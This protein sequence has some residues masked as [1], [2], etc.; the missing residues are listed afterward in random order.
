MSS[1]WRQAKS[2]RTRLYH[3]SNFQN[4]HACQSLG[5]QINSLK[6]TLI[7]A[8]KICSE[9]MIAH[10][11]IYMGSLTQSKAWVKKS[12][13]KKRCLRIVYPSSWMQRFPSSKNNKPIRKLNDNENN[14]NDIQR[15][16]ASLIV[17]SI[18]LVGTFL[19]ILSSTLQSSQT[20]N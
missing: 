11:W 15:R 12:I 7:S 8:S 2:K 16:G 17:C 5:A 3:F 1:W 9:S 18:D 10:R 13:R 4:Y 20:T 6:R 19:S 14:Y